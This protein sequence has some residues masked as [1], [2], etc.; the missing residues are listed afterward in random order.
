MRIDIKTTSPTT[1]R[2]AIIKNIEGKQFRTWEIVKNDKGNKLLNHTSA[3]YTNK[4]LIDLSVLKETLS[5]TPN[6][7]KNT[8]EPDEATKAVIMGNFT[9]LLLTY[10]TDDFTH[11]ETFS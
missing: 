7:W 9:A 2:N 4:V 6:W 1:L 5:A 11:L 8:G 3:Q 10:Y